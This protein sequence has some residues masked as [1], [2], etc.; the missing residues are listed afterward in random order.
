MA[1]KTILTI[2]CRM[3]GKKYLIAWP[4]V[5]RRLMCEDGADN[6]PVIDVPVIRPVSLS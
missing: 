3:V 4:N 5:V 6:C 1:K 2:P